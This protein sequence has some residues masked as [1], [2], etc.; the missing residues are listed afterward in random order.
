MAVAAGG[1]FG[2]GSY[3]AEW[4]RAISGHAERK[5]HGEVDGLPIVTEAPIRF[6]LSI[7]IY[8]L[9]SHLESF[10]INYIENDSIISQRLGFGISIVK[11]TI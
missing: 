5:L 11:K 4:I 6:F 7:E 3:V 8:L 2:Q 1:A 10:I 9:N